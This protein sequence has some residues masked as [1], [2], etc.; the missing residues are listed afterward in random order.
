[1][2]TCR[3]TRVCVL[4]AVGLYA[5]AG[6]SGHARGTRVV[7]QSDKHYTCQPNH[8]TVAK[9]NSD[10]KS[11]RFPRVNKYPVLIPVRPLGITEHS[12]GRRSVK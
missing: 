8:R 2:N 4:P 7:L 11:H 3:C 6:A 5:C 12:W 1:M 9:P 10:G